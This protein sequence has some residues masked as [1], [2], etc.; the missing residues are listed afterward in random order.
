MSEVSAIAIS[1]AKP[2]CEEKL[3]EALQGLLAPTHKENGMLQYDMFCDT[4]EPG[5]FVFIERWENEETFN[6]HCNSP[7]VAAYL[8]K[9]DGWV[10]SNKIYVLRKGK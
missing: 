5:C 7:H 8:E 2:G 3:A 4:Q 1:V 9:T 10:E 6:A